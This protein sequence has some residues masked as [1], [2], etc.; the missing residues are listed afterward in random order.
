[1]FVPE[2]KKAAATV[3]KDTNSK[4]STRVMYFMYYMTIR[5]C[6]IIDW[7]FPVKVQKKEK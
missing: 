4:T 6:E 3:V 5:A 1:M 2:M 7:W